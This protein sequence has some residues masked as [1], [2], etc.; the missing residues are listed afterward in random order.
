MLSL[1]NQ[2]DGFFINLQEDIMT[3]VMKNSLIVY[4]WD[5][6]TLRDLAV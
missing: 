6:L 3:F 5:I 4:D 1:E 2:G